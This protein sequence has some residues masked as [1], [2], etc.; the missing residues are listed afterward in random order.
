[1]GIKQS[2]SGKEIHLARKLQAS[3]KR[4]EMFAYHPILACKAQ[5]YCVY[6][7][8]SRDYKKPTQ[9]RTIWQKM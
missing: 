7:Q 6:K 3:I 2:K 9:T 4:K 1:M 8:V 5:V